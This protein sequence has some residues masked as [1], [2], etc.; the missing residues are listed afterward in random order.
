[1]V[2]ILCRAAD[3]ICVPAQHVHRRLADKERRT[4]R[5]TFTIGGGTPDMSIGS[6]D[7][8]QAGARPY[9]HIINFLKVSQKQVDLR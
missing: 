8:D 1:M 7:A 9:Q 2:N 6:A 5:S 3:R 4:R